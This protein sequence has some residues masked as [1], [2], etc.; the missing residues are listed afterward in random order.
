MAVLYPQ[1]QFFDGNGNPLADGVVYTY[2]SGTNTPKSTWTT[3]AESANHANPVQLDSQGRAAI[4]LSTDSEY[5]I[6]VYTAG[7][8]AT[9][10]QVGPTLDNITGVG[11]QLSSFSEFASDID[12]NG[13]SIISSSNG[14]IN[15]TPNGSGD[16]KATV[17]SGSIDLD[18]TTGDINLK[19]TSGAI[20][21]GHKATGPG[22]VRF[23][24]D[25]DNG[26]NYIEVVGV[27]SVASNRTQT[28][29][30][31]NGTIRIGNKYT[32]T[33][34]G[35][36]NLQV[37]GITTTAADFTLNKITFS[38]Y[39]YTSVDGANVVLTTLVGGSPTTS[40]YAG[41]YTLSDGTTVT[42]GTISVNGPDISSGVGISNTGSTFYSKI[43]GTIERIDNSHGYFNIVS[44]FYNSSDA[45]RV[46][47]IAGDCDNSATVLNGIRLTPSSG[48]ITGTLVVEAS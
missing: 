22:S 15:F 5:R 17:T 6:K 47:R 4:W 40:G 36:A 14:D 26:T 20:N 9:G 23:L 35:A 11:I 18:S 46:S 10:S 24:E 45:I 43:M 32:G 42:T 8:I 28:L 16:V 41:I 48:T 29:T 21:V 33:A 30:D 31:G 3:A 44:I 37:T 2:I 1:L 19:T 12:V 34:A 7:G 38:G 25:T 39:F 13:Y 27:S